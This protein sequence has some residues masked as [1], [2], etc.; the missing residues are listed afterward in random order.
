MLDIPALGATLLHSLWQA[1]ALA[2]LLWSVSR[3]RGLSAN[4]RY[5][6]GFAALL[7]QV[8]LSVATYLHYHTPAPRLEANVKQLVIEWVAAP[9]AALPAPDYSSPN[10]WMH[11]LVILWGISSLVGLLRTVIGFGRVRRMQSLFG[12]LNDPQAHGL[13]RQLGGRLGYTGPLTVRVGEGIAA[14]LLTGFLKP[15]LLLPLALTNQL[16]T[17]EAETV[18]LHELAHLRR[19]DHWF[20]LL[21]CGIEVL[22]YYH[23]AIH[24]ISARVRQEREY[25]CDDLVLAYGPGGL[26]YARALLHYGEQRQTTSP[27]TALSL[28]DGDGLLHRVQRFLLHQPIRYTMKRTLFLL[29]L[30]AVFILIATAVSTPEAVIPS[31]LPA[32]VVPIAIGTPAPAPLPPPDTLPDG[33]HEMTRIRNGEVTKVR[34]EDGK[35]KELQ[36]EGRQV[37]P[38][39]FEENEELAE[40]LLEGMDPD[41]R[42]LRNW[43]LNQDGDRFEFEF[44]DTKQL[45]G[46]AFRLDSV[47]RQLENFQ[48]ERLNFQ[49]DSAHHLLGIAE[50]FNL[51]SFRMEHFDRFEMMEDFDFRF[52]F[53]SLNLERLER[54]EERLEQ[55]LERLRERKRRLTD[56]P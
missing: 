17:E 34:V 18:L 48:L 19:Y 7:A 4:F 40:E 37:P 21:Q 41:R 27:K 35:I 39:E 2:A 10:Y 51:D 5:R 54:E 29:P 56:K 55:R 33:K 38:E 36:I 3:L 9:A 32:N 20:N 49:L 31:E 1:T 25:C 12:K 22:F 46:M 45:E 11:A 52:P 28:T 43:P 14:P 15:V 24:W 30:L 42:Y 16:T 13:I 50:R 6:F 44:P 47:S 23:P 53:D 8:V 26:P